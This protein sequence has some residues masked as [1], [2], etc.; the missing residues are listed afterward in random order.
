MDDAQK[1]LAGK[2]PIPLI[3]RELVK[4]L[5]LSNP[6][7]AIGKDETLAEANRRAGF[8]DLIDLLDF[9]SQLQAQAERGELDEESME[10]LVYEAPTA[11]QQ[12]DGYVLRIS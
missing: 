11:Q 7:R 3:S 6:I 8:Q 12:E 9:K 10:M 4:W 2:L 5:R 1:E